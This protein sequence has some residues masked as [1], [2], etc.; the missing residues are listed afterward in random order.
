MYTV[1]WKPL[2]DQQAGRI[3][4]DHPSLRDRFTEL[5]REIV[6]R[7]QR[8]PQSCG[9]SRSGKTRVLIEEFLVLYFDVVEDDSRVDVLA[10]RKV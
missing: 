10:I 2:A 6:E 7:F 9:E 3:W 8:D 5:V 4:L 1:V